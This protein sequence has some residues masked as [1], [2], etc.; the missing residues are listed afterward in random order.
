[1]NNFEPSSPEQLKQFFDSLRAKSMDEMISLF[2]R[3]ARELGPFKRERTHWDGKTETPAKARS[4][5]ERV[6]YVR[7]LAAWRLGGRPDLYFRPGRLG[8]GT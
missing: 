5:K 3:P 1:M 7:F 4:R 6:D 8:G 2:G